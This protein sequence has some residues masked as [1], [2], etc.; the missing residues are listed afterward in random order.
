MLETI[1]P[2]KVTKN[3]YL[4]LSKLSMKIKLLLILLLTLG[5]SQAQTLNLK[6][7]QKFTY[8]AT[9][10]SESGD[11]IYRSTSY[12]Y[13]KINFKVLNKKDGLYKLKV[14][15]KMFIR[16]WFDGVQDSDLPFAEQQDNLMAIA[17]KVLT[18]SSYEIELDKNGDIQNIEGVPKI[19]KAFIAKLKALDISDGVQKHTELAER[20]FANRY[21]KSQSSFFKTL[22]SS[23]L[24]PG[25]L[26]RSSVIDTTEADVSFGGSKNSFTHKIVK[27]NLVEFAGKATSLSTQLLPEAKEKL[28]YKVYSLPIR[29][30]NR[31]IRELVNLFVSDSGSQTVRCK[32]MKSLDSL[33]K[34]FAVNDYEYLAAKLGVLH[35]TGTGYLDVIK[36]VPYNYLPLSADV[37]SKINLELEKGDL[38]NVK[39]A[40]ELSFTKFRG[41]W[42]YPLNMANTSNNIHDNLGAI[43]YRI[44]SKDSLQRILNIIKQ[45]EG[46]QI[47]IA[48]EM[49]KGMKTFV[50]AKLAGTQKELADVANTQFNSI[51]DMAGRYRILIYD[52]LVRKQLPDSIKL[53]YIDYTID[54]DKKRIDL[55][56]SGR[57]QNVDSFTLKYFIAPNI[58]VYKKNLADAY[59]R[60][61]VLRKNSKIA[62]LQLAADYMPTQQDL[63]D[64]DSVLETEY[65]FTPYVSYT[66]L[67]LAAGGSAGMSTEDKLRKDVDMVILD[68]ERYTSLKEKYL[69]AYPK[70]NFSTFFSDALKQKLPQIPNFS[71]TER[72][73]STVTNTNQGN[74]F[75]FVDFWGTWC[76]ACVDE[77]DKIESVYLQNPDP[78]KLMI[79]TIACHDQKKNVD[80]F[81]AR[82]KFRYPVLMSDARVER[83]FKITAYPTKLLLL[84]NG[85]YLSIPYCSS[86]NA[87]LSKY[88]KWEM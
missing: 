72:K 83:D 9:I 60:R 87:I 21:F 85:V 62:Y 15:P 37:D 25:G 19:K 81:M 61:S 26:I 16:N 75:V 30:A 46:L 40:V 88:L 73:G 54:L 17:N 1:K 24:G 49:M 13:W 39:K 52:E 36:Q 80:D 11:A 33:D 45:V 55:I 42:F 28:N 2:N 22:G 84:P 20:I 6:K 76:G 67:F 48:T 56:N 82:E 12:E 23:T 7:G 51:F 29:K 65:K 34:G 5:V 57:I 47:P 4:E 74:K 79:T 3:S 66:D 53:S 18:M 86:Y 78:D 69:K 50:E 70:G 44:K 64:D 68:P 32:I 8:D 27:Y 35:H 10:N 59:Y 41:Q 71:L 58:I 77:I 31:K 14:F 43:V 38:S 63:I